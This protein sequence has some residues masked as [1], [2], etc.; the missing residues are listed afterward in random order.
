MVSRGKI[1]SFVSVY[2]TK[3][4]LLLVIQFYRYL[5]PLNSGWQ[6]LFELG[7]IKVGESYS[8]KNS[9]KKKEKKEP[10]EETYS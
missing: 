8:K 10:I 1:D 3:G 7:S 9:R 5:F 4:D 6:R 2:R